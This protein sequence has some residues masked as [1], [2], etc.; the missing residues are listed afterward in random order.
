MAQAKDIIISAKGKRLGRLATEVAT[1]LRGK[2]ESSYER[3]VMPEV[4]VAVTDAGQ[5]DISERKLGFIE[6]KRYSG[7]PGGLTVRTGK[8]VAALKGNRELIKK[9]IYGM[10]PKNKLRAKIIKNLTITE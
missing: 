1:L 3:H 4:T 8:Q 7:Y 10:L 5:L 2:A 9:A 6:H